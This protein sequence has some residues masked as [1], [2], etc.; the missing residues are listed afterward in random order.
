MP[1]RPRRCNDDGKEEIESMSRFCFASIK[2]NEFAETGTHEEHPFI[3]KFN[4]TFRGTYTPRQK[5]I[6]E[7]IVIIYQLLPFPNTDGRRLYLVVVTV[8]RE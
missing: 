1:T 8:F 6:A 3:S 7:I 5:N 4:Y 2:K